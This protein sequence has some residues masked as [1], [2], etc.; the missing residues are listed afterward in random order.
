MGVLR[1]AGRGALR[2]LNHAL[3]PAIAVIVAFGLAGVVVA[4][5]GNN[6]VSVYRGLWVGAGFDYPF[7][8]LPG[9][10]FGVDP[11]LSAFNLQQTLNATTPLILAGLAVAFAFRAG[12][13]N[14]GGTG[15]FW[16]GGIAAFFVADR[17]TDLPGPLLILLAVLSALAT[18]AIYGAIPGYLKAW[19]GAHEVISTIMLNWIAIYVGQYLFSGP[20]KAP[21]ENPI[22]PD[23][24]EKT[25]Y[26]QLWGDIQGV[27]IGLFV[28]LGAAVVF[29]LIFR[30]STLGYD[31]RAV[32]LN[33][34][35]ARAGGVGV[36]RTIVLTMAISGAF[37]G[38]AGAGEVLGLNHHIASNEL[39][40][41]QIG[42]IGIAVALLGRNTAI[43]T[44]F[45]ALLF[46]ALQS[47][48]N[49]LQAE[50]SPELAT[51]LSLIVQGIIVLL[52]SAEHLVRLVIRHRVKPDAP[53]ET[54]DEVV[55][56]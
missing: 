3:F 27:H 14:I 52:V 4:I 11:A 51:A 41:V 29:S 9:N 2:V 19:R 26:P 44:V 15:Q 24:P 25:Y 16:V 7:H 53:P 20:L 47:G 22:S 17:L 54:A 30:R 36:K 35:A 28:A 13:F 50:F 32:G 21:G 38:L 45:A 34:E 1:A 49:N 31:V 12:L 23:L 18:S 39:A 5:T 10:P 43:G 48:S 8:W 6:P 55:A 56:T 37:A 46:G 40:P 42:F 33:P